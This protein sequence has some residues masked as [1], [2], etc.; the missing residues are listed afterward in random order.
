M[1]ANPPSSENDDVSRELCPVLELDACFREALNLAV[2][3]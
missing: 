1:T 2:R 3:F